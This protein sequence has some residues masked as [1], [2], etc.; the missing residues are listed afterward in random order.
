MF[1]EGNKVEVVLANTNPF[2]DDIA[3]AEL[4]FYSP[5]VGPIMMTEDY[6][7]GSVES[8]DLTSQ[9]FKWSV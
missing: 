3:I 5:R 2:S 1:K 9:R 8:C 4:I 6:K 7:E